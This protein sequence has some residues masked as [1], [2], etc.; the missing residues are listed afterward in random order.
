M[1]CYIWIKLSMS[2][3]VFLLHQ[4]FSTPIQHWNKFKGKPRR[5]QTTPDLSEKMWTILRFTKKH[6]G[7]IGICIVTFI[8]F[9]GSM[10]LGYQNYM[11]EIQRLSVQ[12]NLTTSLE[13]FNQWCRSDPCMTPAFC[14]IMDYLFKTKLCWHR[15]CES[16]CLDQLKTS[17]CDGAEQ[18][19]ERC[20]ALK[21]EMMEQRI[22]LTGFLFVLC[23]AFFGVLCIMSTLICWCSDYVKFTNDER[24]QQFRK[25]V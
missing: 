14:N 22:D 6:P 4:I 17:P 2:E 10:L 25:L 5:H 21:H 18:C 24:E 13:P 8:L 20:V 9:V 3:H 1:L 15:T 12:K 19:T 7:S 23:G 16:I 11:T